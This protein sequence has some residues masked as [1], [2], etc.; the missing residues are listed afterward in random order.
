[1][2]AF[3]VLVMWVCNY[4]LDI[5]VL[6]KSWDDNFIIKENEREKEKRKWFAPTI[7]FYTNI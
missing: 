6:I 7:I 4:K 5:N 2:F 1:M 3:P